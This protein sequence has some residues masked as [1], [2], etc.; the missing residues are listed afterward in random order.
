MVKLNEL[1]S[2]EYGNQLDFNKLTQVKNKEGIRFISRS[3]EN[4]GF[5][6]YVKEIKGDK[7]YK[8]GSI[9][10]TLGGSYLLSAFIQPAPFYTAQNIKVLTPKVEMTHLQKLYYCYA[11]KHNRYRFTTHGREAN[12][13]LDFIQVPSM[14]EIPE[15]VTSTK[16][17]NPS[18]KSFLTKDISL[19]A[20]KWDW[21]VY[22]DLFD[23]ERG[24]GGRITDISKSAKIPFITSIDSNN[25]LKGYVSKN[26]HHNSNV[27]TVNRNGSVAE[28][29]YQDRA[30]NSTEDV[31]V[32]SAKFELNVYIALFLSTLIKREK[33]RFG[34]GRKWGLERMRKSKIKLPITK[35]KTPDWQ[36][37]E[38]YIK[39]LPYSSNLK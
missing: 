31:H 37:M 1:F 29:F 16:I 14:N 4:L 39:S 25:G 15:W 13:T 36:F 27:I 12:K 2:I 3:S 22:G 19:N 30:F 21:F 7:I 18:S 23:I 6:G 24:K 32:F 10:V 26:P 33:Y 28:A 35:D 8:T 9:T 5:Q 38:H 34:Y 11:I 17:K 20:R